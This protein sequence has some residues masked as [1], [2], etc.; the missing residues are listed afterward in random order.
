MRNVYSITKW[1]LRIINRYIYANFAKNLFED[2]KF[3]KVI[4]YRIYIKKISK[5]QQNKFN[6]LLDVYYA[7]KIF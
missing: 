6:S 2:L 4:Y 5:T 1:I 3:I 7:T